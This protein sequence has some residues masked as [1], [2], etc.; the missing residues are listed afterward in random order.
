MQRLI[1][2][3]CERCFCNA[4]H[5]WEKGTNLGLISDNE[6]FQI[7]KIINDSSIK[8]LNWSSPADVSSSLRSG[9]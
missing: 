1:A 5:S 6:I 8:L 9:Y 2:L 4:Y 7:Q 3:G